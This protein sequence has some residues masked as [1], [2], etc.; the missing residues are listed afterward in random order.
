MIYGVYLLVYMPLK[1]LVCGWTV[2]TLW[3]WFVVTTF[4]LAPLRVA[5]AIGLALLIEF[6][7]PS[8]P[9]R[10]SKDEVFKEVFTTMWIYAALYLVLKIVFTLAIGY[11]VHRSLG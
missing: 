10:E 7:G 2:Q 11:I 5:E 6:L 9:H 4:G 8:P 3:G 1:A